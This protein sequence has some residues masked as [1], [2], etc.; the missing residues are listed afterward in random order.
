[1]QACRKLTL[2]KIL[3]RVGKIF[4]TLGF[5]CDVVSGTHRRKGPDPFSSPNRRERTLAPLQILGDSG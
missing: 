4:E 1:M 3:R 2:L 5:V